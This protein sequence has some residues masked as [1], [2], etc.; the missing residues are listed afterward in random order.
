MTYVTYVI[1]VCDY[2]TLNTEPIPF[3]SA[4]N[5]PIRYFWTDVLMQH[6]TA[7]MYFQIFYKINFVN[8]TINSLRF[9]FIVAIGLCRFCTLY[10]GWEA[11][12][13]CSL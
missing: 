7:F 5:K 3:Y 6:I 8:S 4:T 10:D 12:E 11:C 9:E 2:V 1:Y 13:V